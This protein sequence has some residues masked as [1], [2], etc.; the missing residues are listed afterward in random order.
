MNPTGLV[1]FLKVSRET[2][3]L[4]SLLRC[5]VVP[6]TSKVAPVVFNCNVFWSE[7][8]HLQFHISAAA[9]SCRAACLRV[10]AFPGRVQGLSREIQAKWKQVGPLHIPGLDNWRNPCLKKQPHVTGSQV[11]LVS[12]PSGALVVKRINAYHG[13]ETVKHAA[14]QVADS[15]T[16]KNS[17]S[18]L[19]WGLFYLNCEAVDYGSFH[20]ISKV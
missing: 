20:P 12:V 15:R 7:S 19:I 16:D 1:P 9:C 18:L 14:G 17:N 11:V 2:W 10:V 8:A 5:S 3:K 13:S 6:E 4:F